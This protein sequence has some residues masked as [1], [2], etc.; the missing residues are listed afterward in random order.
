MAKK[1]AKKSDPRNL[2]GQLVKLFKPGGQIIPLT[3]LPTPQM[4]KDIYT[5]DT[6]PVFVFMNPSEKPQRKDLKSVEI[7]EARFAM[8]SI[9]GREEGHSKNDVTNFQIQVSSNKF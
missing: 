9:S 8:M 2:P 3:L 7:S 1:S 4:Q 5:S 6:S